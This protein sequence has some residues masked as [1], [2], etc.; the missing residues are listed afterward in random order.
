MTHLGVCP[1]TNSS[2][3]GRVSSAGRGLREAWAW[4]RT[5]GTV[6][7]GG[8]IYTKVSPDETI[9]GQFGVGTAAKG[10]PARRGKRLRKGL[11]CCKKGQHPRGWVSLPELLMVVRH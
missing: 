5:G 4:W 1:S 8:K 3:H 9:G 6:G 7:E 11:G 2:A 10:M